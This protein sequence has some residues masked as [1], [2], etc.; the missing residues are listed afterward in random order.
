MNPYSHLVLVNKIEYLVQ[1][2][3]SG[4]YYW[5]AIAPDV[6][7]I[8]GIDRRRT[9]LTKENCIQLIKQFPN[10]KSFLQGYLVHCLADEISL[11]E[12]FYSTFPFSIIKDRLSR[13]RIAVLLELFYIKDSSFTPKIAGTYNQVLSDLGLQAED[14]IQFSEIVDRYLTS[15]SLDAKISS[16]VGMMGSKNNE[17]VEKYLSA[18][19]YFQN[20]IFLQKFLLLSIRVGRI[21]KKIESRLSALLNNSAN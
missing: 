13:K 9:H 20:N 6:R 2:E 15:E 12:I 14:C 21:S 7:Y 8:A 10:L 5:G 19:K 11:H 4:E 16:L 17:N 3:N 1:P 18:A